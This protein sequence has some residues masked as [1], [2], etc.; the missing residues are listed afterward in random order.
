MKILQFGST[1]TVGSA[2][3]KAFEELDFDV[4]AFNLEE[5]KQRVD[6]TDSDSISAV[7]ESVGE[8]DA[9]VCTVGVVPLK[10]LAEM[11]KAD[12]TEAIN[13]KLSSQ[14]DLVLQGLKFVRPRI[15]HTHF[16]SDVPYALAGGHRRHH[17][18][19]RLGCVR[20]RCSG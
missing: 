2:V 14:V 18:R 4:V 20:A 19:R 8:V 3:L 10:P 5:G 15:F 16:W 17:C 11:T 6:I 13:G 9:V 7:Y 12:V 1:G